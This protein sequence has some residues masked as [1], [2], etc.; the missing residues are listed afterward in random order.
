MSDTSVL[1]PEP[2]ESLPSNPTINILILSSLV[3]I[4]NVVSGIFTQ[5]YLY[6]LLF[7]L[8]TITS[9]S[10]HSNNTIF[11]NVIDKLVILAI[12]IYGA[13]VFYNKITSDKWITGVIVLLSCFIV[14]YLYIYGYHAKN[15]CFH[16]EKY[17][18][19]LYHCMMHVVGSFGHHLIMFL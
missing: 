14:I 12:A 13:Y 16:N 11:I 15:Y 1:Q 4:T 9:V 5:D 19:E 7:A 2:T 10:V 6:S 3:F 18:A 8:L 17:V